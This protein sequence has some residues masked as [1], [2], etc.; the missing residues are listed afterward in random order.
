[1]IL[2]LF[3]EFLGFEWNFEFPLKFSEK[4]DAKDKLGIFEYFLSY[5]YFYSKINAEII[6]PH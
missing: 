3:L 1:M 5:K 2:S 6:F 4:K